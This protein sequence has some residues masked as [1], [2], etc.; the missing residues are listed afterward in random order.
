MRFRLPPLNDRRVLKRLSAYTVLSTVAVLPWC[1]G[2]A[3]EFT[4]PLMV[5]CGAVASLGAVFSMRQRAMA[6]PARLLLVLLSV[7]MVASVVQL[8]PLPDALLQRLSPRALEVRDFVLA[9]LGAPGAVPVS[10]D[11]RATT[12]A[13]GRAL[14]LLLLAFAAQ[15]A[16][17]QPRGFRRLM[18]LGTLQGAALALC[19]LG[20]FVVGAERLFGVYRFQS[21]H[22]MLTPFGDRNHLAAFLILTSVMAL[23]LVVTASAPKLR[24]AAAVSAALQATVVVLSM[25]RGGIGFLAVSWACVAALVVARKERALRESRRYRWLPWVLLGVTL[26]AAIALSYEPLL[27]RWSSMNSLERL[28]A[29]KIGQWPM[30]AEAAKAF[31]PLGMGNGTFEIGFGAYETKSYGVTFTH[32][33]NL[34]LQWLNELGLPLT[35]LLVVVALT[36]WIQCFRRSPRTEVRLVLFGLAGVVA[37]DLVDFALEL[38]AVAPMA[39]V[40]A[41]ALGGAVGVK[42]ETKAETKTASREPLDFRRRWALGVA[43]GGVIG[44]ACYWVGRPTH[45]EDE[46]SMV[47]LLSNPELGQPAV[48]TEAM[49]RHPSDWVMAAQQARLAKNP[50][51]VLAWVNRWLFLR[52]IDSEAHATAALALLKLNRIDQA[53]GEMRLGFV[54]GDYT[55]LPWGLQIGRK[56]NDF[57]GLFVDAPKL[58]EAGASALAQEPE[59]AKRWLLQAS[60]ESLSKASTETASRL[61]IEAL[62]NQGLA[63]DAAARLSTLGPLDAVDL[64]TGIVA[65]RTLAAAQKYDEALQ[66]LGTLTVKHPADV[67][68]QL[69]RAEVFQASGQTQRAHATLDAVLPLVNLEQRGQIL[70]RKAVLLQT[71]GSLREALEVWQRVGRLQAPTAEHFYRIAGLH[72]QLGANFSALEALRRGRALDSPEG[73]KAK[74]DWESKLKAASP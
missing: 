57:R 29:T 25:S 26:M 34:L 49:L 43:L 72:E 45:L 8:I 21:N 73:A 32:P 2:G 71:A 48:S 36:F 61:L 54:A 39:V 5:A 13:L 70:Q 4:S 30:F 15:R 46:A 41:A 44:V 53:M 68:L 11:T 60:E 65:A 24:L 33:E 37:H 58:I 28:S 22:V 9:P 7:S 50:N 40:V 56:R 67:P 74:A 59:F 63:A 10:L 23:A 47:Q 35:V 31:W 38:N 6:Q 19:A 14:G 18:L 27:E 66:L 1:L 20:H 12:R 42:T 17:S 55:A 62:L 52:P 64:Q 69:L 51:N 3:L 16:L